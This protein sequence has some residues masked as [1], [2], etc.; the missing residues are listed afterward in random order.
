MK[1]KFN[2][3]F[4]VSRLFLVINEFPLVMSARALIIKAEPARPPA[5][6]PAF[7]CLAK[8]ES[9]R[10]IHKFVKIIF[11]QNNRPHMM[12]PV[13]WLVQGMLDL[14]KQHSLFFLTIEGKSCIPVLY[15]IAS[16]VSWKKAPK[17]AGGA[18][19]FPRDWSCNA[20]LTALQA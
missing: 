9:C 20:G 1:K 10:C 3:H 7:T 16:I 14:P 11:S 18:L 5:C 17:T 2:A 4:L 19:V 12:W 15:N 8:T 6:L 13:S